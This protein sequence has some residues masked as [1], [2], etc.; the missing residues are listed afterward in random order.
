LILALK[1]FEHVATNLGKN[2][3]N[4]NTYTTLPSLSRT[5]FGSLLSSQT[6]TVAFLKITYGL[7]NI[8]TYVPLFV[9][10]SLIRMGVLIGLFLLLVGFWCFLGYKLAHLPAVAPIIERYNRI[11]LPF[12]FL[13]LGILILVETGTGVL[14]LHL[15]RFR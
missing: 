8:C 2:W 7:D 4:K 15:M 9:S 12:V 11:L 3:V 1:P 5:V 13:V 6:Y 10:G 14:L